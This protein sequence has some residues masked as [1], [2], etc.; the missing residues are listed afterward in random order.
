MFLI[1]SFRVAQVKIRF[2]FN[3]V[4]QYWSLIAA[5]VGESKKLL[6]VVGDEPSAR[7]G[8]SYACSRPTI[9]RSGSTV[10]ILQSPQVNE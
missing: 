8:Q 4:N 2:K 10:L 9:F 7:L 1:S 6:T 3:V 5:E